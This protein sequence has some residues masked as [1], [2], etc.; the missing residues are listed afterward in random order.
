MN[1]IIT[2]KCVSPLALYGQAQGVARQAA[3]HAV[4][5]SFWLWAPDNDYAGIPGMGM[6]ILLTAQ[7]AD[8]ASSVLE[9]TLEIFFFAG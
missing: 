2:L 7:V 3:I 1:K 4:G 5:R 6:C 9:M 8:L